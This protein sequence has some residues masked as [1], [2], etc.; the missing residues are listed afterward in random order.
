[1]PIPIS[2]KRDGNSV[3]WL[4]L[5]L[6]LLGAAS[7]LGYLLVV[8]RIRG[9]S[10][11]L[12]WGFPHSDFL[13]LFLIYFIPLFLLAMAGAWW[14]IRSNADDTA[15]LGLIVGFALLFRLL[16]LPT[17]PVLSSDIFRYVWDARIQASG[18]NPYLSRP[19]DFDSEHLR[20]DPLYQQQ[21]RP[22]ARTIYPPLAQMAFRA[23]R[24][25]GGE[26]VTATKALMLLGDLAGMIILMHLLRALGLP[27]GR[28]IVYAWHPLVVFEVAG[29]GHVDALSVPCILLAVLAWQRR[30]DAIAGIALGAATLI[31][32]FPLLLIPA[33]FSRRRWA[34]LLGSGVTILLG[35]LPYVPGAGLQV[36]GHLPRFLADPNEMFNPSL[37]GL[38]FLGTS[39]AS[40]APAY[41]VSWVGKAALLCT[42]AWLLRRDAD[43]FHDLLARIWIMAGAITLFTL[44]LHPWYLLWLVPFLAIQPRPAWLY[45]SGVVAVSY[46]FYVTTPPT[47]ALIGALEYLPFLFLLCW[48]WRRHR[49]PDPA[50]AHLGFARE[51]P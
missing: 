32:I 31:K 27:R 19:A 47:R 6:L 36:L 30:Q 38:V 23:A 33:L 24:A 43:T 1:M 8:A 7:T 37:M 18:V 46:T 25:V 39:I 29:S 40:R 26:N 49:G 28:V 51:I 44:T 34:I 5:R 4:R 35:Y 15:T 11:F 12:S 14:T 3:T 50:G 2:R 10:G 45:L 16:L 21:N 9:I 42:V 17:P 20:K 22:F 48:Q 13:M 41:W